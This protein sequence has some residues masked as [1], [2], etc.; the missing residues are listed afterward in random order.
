MAYTSLAKLN[1]AVSEQ[2]ISSPIQGSLL[3]ILVNVQSKAI[4]TCVT[5]MGKANCVGRK[6]NRRYVCKMWVGG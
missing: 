5:V 1:W 4:F 3:V 6:N 2:N